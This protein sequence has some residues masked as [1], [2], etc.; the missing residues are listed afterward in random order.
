[1]RLQY[2]SDLEAEHRHLKQ[3]VES[4]KI[5]LKDAK[6]LVRTLQEAARHSRN[7]SSS[8]SESSISEQGYTH[9]TSKTPMLGGYTGGFAVD[10]PVS[11]WSM[12]YTQPFAGGFDVQGFLKDMVAK[13]P[14]PAGNV[15]G[16]YSQI[17]FSVCG[18]G[19]Q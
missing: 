7:D 17:E 13:S 1:M 14:M 18:M 10:A 2:V 16:K 15:L 8:S 4:Q 5:E 3:L 6:E 11:P 9:L 12:S 19:S